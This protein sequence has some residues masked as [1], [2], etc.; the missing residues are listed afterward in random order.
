VA[1]ERRWGAGHLVII[2]DA[3]P[4]SNEALRRHRQ[5]DWLAW[6]LGDA[7]QVVFEERHLGI[8]A[9]PGV[10]GL[11]RRYRLHGLAAG[12]CLL[13]ALWVWQTLATLVPRREA[14]TQS[15]PVAGHGSEQGLAQLLRRVVRPDN[16][17]QIWVEAWH[18][19]V[20]HDPSWRPTAADLQIH[21]HTRPPNLG[22]RPSPLQ[23]LSDLHS[24]VQ[25]RSRLGPRPPLALPK[26]KL[27]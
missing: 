7:S 9:V 21:L 18:H 16:L 19:S 27:Q 3:Y 20:G 12:L 13:A 1:I 26:P 2:T 11:A 15:A 22:E 23:T 17:P 8:E 10:A 14:A 6:L 4:L 5:T 24:L 25:T